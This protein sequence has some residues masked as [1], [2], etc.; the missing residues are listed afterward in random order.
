MLQDIL[1]AVR[2]L[3]RNPGFSVIARPRSREAMKTVIRRIRQLEDQFGSADGRPRRCLRLLVSMAGSKPSLEN[4]T[5]NRTLYSDGSLL[6]LVRFKKHKEGPDEL[7]AEE[8]DK[9]VETFPVR[10]LCFE[11]R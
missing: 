1:H 8:L 3:R 4:A 11:S 6:E 7:T 5:C 2:Q 9:W 10:D